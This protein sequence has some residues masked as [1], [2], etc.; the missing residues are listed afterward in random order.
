MVMLAR[1]LGLPDSDA[2][3]LKEYGYAGMDQ[4]DGF[5]SDERCEEV[6]NRLFDLGPIGATYALGVSDNSP[7]PDTIIGACMRAVQAGE[8]D[9]VEA[10]MILTLVTI[11]GGESTTSLLGTGARLLAGNEE[12]QE[13]L[14]AAPQLVTNFVEEACRIDPPFRGHYR[15]AT[16]ERVLGGDTARR[17]AGARVRASVATGCGVAEALPPEARSGSV[18]SPCQSSAAGV[19]VPGRDGAGVELRRR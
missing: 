11:A 19:T 18:T 12:L 17:C 5:A 10:L 16:R 2:P 15:R 6:R 7:G 9:D 3:A 8:L 4:I 13:Q 14:R 1:L